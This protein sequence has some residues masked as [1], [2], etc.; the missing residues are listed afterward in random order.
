MVEK[1]PQA[2]SLSVQDHRCHVFA[3][4]LTDGTVVMV[5]AAHADDG[6]KTRRAFHNLERDTVYTRFF[7]TRPM[8]AMPTLLGSLK[9]ILRGWSRNW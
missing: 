2:W 1:D 3:E 4:T 8:S 7:G 5:R 6:R 9:R